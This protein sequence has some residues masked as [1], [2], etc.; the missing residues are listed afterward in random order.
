M[1]RRLKRSIRNNYFIPSSKT[2][3]QVY[4]DQ[5]RYTM[6]ALIICAIIGMAMSRLLQPVIPKLNP[7]IAKSSVSDVA[8]LIAFG[9]CAILLVILLLNM[10]SI[11]KVIMSA[12]ERRRLK[13]FNEKRK[14]NRTND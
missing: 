11:M 1:R 3:K 7:T 12:N 8:N 10:K 9:F 6:Y 4:S 2:F 5:G 14:S 13:A